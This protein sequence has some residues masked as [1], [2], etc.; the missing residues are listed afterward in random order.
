[1]TSRIAWTNFLPAVLAVLGLSI[2]GCGNGVPGP[3]GPQGEPGPAGPAGQAVVDLGTASDDDFAG[4]EVQSEITGVT[5]A[6]PPV[7]NFT[8]TTA[9]GTPITGIGALWEDSNRFVRFTLTKLVAGTNGDPSTWVA[10]T[11]DTTNDGS[12]P[13]DYDT[14]SS[15][16][17]NGD[18][19]YVFTFNTDVAEVSGVTYE[20]T[21]SHRVAGQIGSGSSP[22][23]AQNL[24]MDFVPGGG[25]VTETRNIVTM[26]SCNEC[27]EDLVFHGRRFKVEYCVNCHTPELAMGEGDMAFMTHKIHAAQKF[28]VLDEGID[29]SEVTYPQDLANCR[30]CHT[31]DDEATPDGDNWNTVPSIMACG[32]CHQTS[33]V[34]PAPEGMTL[35]SAGPQADNSGC[36]A[37]HPASGGIAGIEDSHLT[38]NATPNN[39]N[40][41]AS[42]PAMEFSVSAVTVDGGGNPTVTFKVTADGE[43]LDL[44]DL[45]DGFVDGDGN[46]FRW[47]VF[48]MAWAEA[49]DGIANP[50]DYTNTGQNGGQPV[51]VDLGDLVAAAGIDCSSGTDCVADFASTGN[52]FPAGSMLRAVGLQGYFQFDT[53][54]DEAQDASLHTLSAVAAVTGDEIRREIV[55][56]NKCGA[57]HEWFEGHGG[58]RVVGLNEKMPMDPSICALCHVPNLSTSGRAINPANAA[59]RDGDPLTDDPSAATVALGNSDTWTWPEDTNNFKEMIHGIHAS[60][61]RSN[62][63]QF[64][65]GR[66]DGIFYDWA[67]VTY[68]AEHGSSN[69]LLCHMEGTYELPLAENV[70]DTTV[71]TTGTADGLDGNDFAAVDAARDSV[72]NV[73]D[74]VNTATA[75]TCYYCHDNDLTLAHMRQ[76][77]GV[78]S[79]ANVGADD[80]TQ[81][82]DV[83]NAESCSVCHGGDSISNMNTAHG[84][85]N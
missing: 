54:G 24:V 30:K 77:G 66:N 12:T 84:L 72:P 76:N 45:P 68:P 82:Q 78:I 28:D 2:A 37:C 85:G 47:P 16:V 21:L 10:Y 50:A 15:L 62:D 48:L 32:G 73:N 57:C 17:D 11:R 61:M 71:R 53:D 60:A 40:L 3:Q 6:S 31:S 19:T 8:V 39:P 49:Q 26:N 59:D 64:V 63:Y 55:D 56:S 70:L 43:L 65:R 75:S 22:L 67:E 4:M 44:N 25:A 81:R 34:D 1:M 36:A 74:W 35:H 58:N 69:C 38:L 7:V 27:H 80:F 29:Y 14:G 13:P 33:F 23:P 9:S 51:G 52:A 46:A 5:I 20:P 42:V 79:V 18:G 83:T 41:P